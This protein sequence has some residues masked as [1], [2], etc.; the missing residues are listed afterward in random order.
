MY[1]TKCTIIG[2][3]Y[4][5]RLF[6]NDVLVD[7]MACDEKDNIGWCF[8]EMLRWQDKCGG[9][10][11]FTAAAR[12][13]QTPKPE[14][15]R[16]RFIGVKDMALRPLTEFELAVV[17][18]LLA[19]KTLSSAEDISRRL[20]QGRKGKIAVASALRRLQYRGDN[21]ALDES[22]EA[23]SFAHT[24][25]H[26]Y[27]GRLA[28]EDRWGTARWTASERAWREFAEA[29]KKLPASKQACG[30]CSNAKCASRVNEASPWPCVK[31]TITCY[32]LKH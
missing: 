19:V 11:Q 15:G 29:H 6:R 4:H 23:E 20:G 24:G 27:L 16:I 31:D 13:R 10:D 21:V 1:T 30:L 17:A 25:G 26:H 28:P 22:N 5:C 32:R 9:G 18:A 12:A 7:E 2:N 14:Y 8:R 3:W